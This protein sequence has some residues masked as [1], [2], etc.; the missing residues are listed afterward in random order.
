MIGSA[1][2]TPSQ[3]PTD[4]DPGATPPS[5]TPN[6]EPAVDPYLAIGAAL[7]SGRLADAH[8]LFETEETLEDFE[9]A[10][11]EVVAVWGP[12][13]AVAAV[14]PSHDGK[15]REYYYRFAGVLV[16]A[17]VLRGGS[18]KP[19]SP[20]WMNWQ[21]PAGID[22]AA[23]DERIVELPDPKWPLQGIATVPKNPVAWVVLVHGSGP[24]DRDVLTGP[25]RPFR[26]LAWGL[27]QQ[28]IASLRYDKRT[29]V[30]PAA[31]GAV[32]DGIDVRDE[33]IDD[34]VRAAAAA[35]ELAGGLPL[36]LAGHSFGGYLLPWIAEEVP[37]ATG[38]V[39]LSAHVSPLHVLIPRQM[40]YL[41]KLD[42]DFTVAERAQLTM[43]ERLAADAGKIEAGATT[44]GVTL[45]APNAFWASLHGY[46]PVARMK[47]LG[48]PGL[49]VQGSA[50][51]QVDAG[52]T[53]AWKRGLAKA[54]KVTF[55][56]LPVNHL[57][58]TGTGERGPKEYEIPG[59]V[60]AKVV[61]T[62]GRWIR[63]T[64]SARR[65]RTAVRQ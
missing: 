35:R 29:Y 16:H 61:D 6:P 55:A 59:H 15:V 47:G 5:P 20:R 3:A 45:G 22:L 57:L 30:H 58:M 60:D 10:W 19:T 18:G 40:E 24:H 1:T 7:C 51:Y 38:L 54:T 27:A 34:A 11:A 33:V 28:G 52:E 8:A 64:A 32:A 26:D 23:I 65:A 44:G 14:S 21:P 43:V 9:R 2:E 37:D 63:R 17:R 46:D 48:R 25:N 53:K 49:F 50:D 56:V 42:G 12:C 31:M 41:A 4:R 13:S 62:I 39:F 36:F